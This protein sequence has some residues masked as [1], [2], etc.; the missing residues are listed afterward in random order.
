MALYFS[1][2]DLKGN[3]QALRNMQSQYD[4]V[5]SRRK[6]F[7]E[8][9]K[10]F[11]SL[12][13]NQDVANAAARIPQDV[14]REMESTTKTIMR[15]DNQVL[16]NDLMS[17]TKV[18]PIGKILNEYRQAS[19]SGLVNVSLSG[20]VPGNIDKAQYDY[21]GA[22]IVIHSAAYGREWREMEGQR[23]EGFDGLI[24]DNENTV[25]AVKDS[26]V[27]HVYDGK[28]VTFKGVSAYGIKNAANTALADLGTS[29]INIDFTSA[30]ATSSAQR[31][32][33]LAVLYQLRT[34][35]N[36]TEDV[37][38]YISREIEENWQR[39][40][41]SSGGMANKTILAEFADIAGIGAIKT[42]AKLSGNELIMGVVSDRYIRLLSGMAMSTYPM[43]RNQPF[44][45]YNF[46]VWTAAGLQVKADAQGHTGWLYASA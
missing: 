12:V 5:F 10:S 27:D 9:Q 28:D 41:D 21:D 43:M 31:A 32:A 4:H 19:D 11:E 30:A 20:Q 46:M 18:L 3:K 23:S 42:D 15:A 13:G 14:Y 16:L 37:T 6:V 17:T 29:G 36:V 8:M 34:D 40:Y 38:L 44:D 26:L 35:N 39:I 7:N 25:R 2:N 45:N 1:Q 24:D 33:L 22:I